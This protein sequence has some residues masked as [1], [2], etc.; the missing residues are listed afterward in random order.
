[1]TDALSLIRDYTINKKEIEVRD[2]LVYLGDFCWDVKI[3]G[4]K[5]QIISIQKRAIK[6]HIQG[7]DY[8][9]KDKVR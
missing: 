7:H 9:H 3:K 5:L 2:G 8:N 4:S 6:N 1:M